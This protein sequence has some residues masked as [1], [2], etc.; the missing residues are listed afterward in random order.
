MR[1]KNLPVGATVDDVF[2]TTMKE[3]KLLVNNNEY[4]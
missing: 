1:M 4:R 3:R 2:G